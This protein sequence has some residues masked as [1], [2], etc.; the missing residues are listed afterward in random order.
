MVELWRRIF[1]LAVLST[2]CGGATVADACEL[3]QVVAPHW[4]VHSENGAEWLVDP[5]GERFY[6]VGINVLDSEVPKLPLPD[7]RKRYEWRRFYPS[8]ATWRDDTVQRIRSWGFNTAGAWSLPPGALQLPEVANLELGRLAR[9]HWFDPFDPATEQT[10]RALA[11]E[12][13][14]PYKGSPYRIGYFSDNEVGWWSGA[15]FVFYSAK[16][17]SNHTKQRWVELLRDR[18]GGA[19]EKFVADFVPPDGVGTCGKDGQGVPVGVGQPSLR[20]D[21]LT[22]GGTAN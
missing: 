4:G 18:Y 12:L 7:G 13:V 11:P 5:C 22:V 21:G 9:F 14:T 17:A 6:S 10:M 16:P 20:I 1:R 2:L 15:L 8:L 19:W 3:A